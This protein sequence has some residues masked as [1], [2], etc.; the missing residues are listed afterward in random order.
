MRFQG[1]GLLCI[2]RH[3]I[4]QQKSNADSCRKKEAGLRCMDWVYSL[5][6]H[7]IAL[8][9]RPLKLSRELTLLYKVRYGRKARKAV[10]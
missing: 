2:D 3:S 7:P 5:S 8:L 4:P 10:W 1:V 6:E 9:G